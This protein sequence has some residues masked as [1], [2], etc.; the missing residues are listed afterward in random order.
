VD[1]IELVQD[2]Q[3]WASFISVP[4]LWVPLKQGVLG[5]V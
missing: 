1:W 5:M 4:N 3:W 2:V